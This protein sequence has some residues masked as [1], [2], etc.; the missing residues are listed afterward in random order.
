VRTKRKRNMKMRSTLLLA[1][2]LA[3]VAKPYIHFSR[4]LAAIGSV[5]SLARRPI[6]SASSHGSHKRSAPQASYCLPGD[7]CWPSASAWAAL[8]VSVGGSLISILPEGYPCTE[9]ASEACSWVQGNW[10]DPFW[11][12]AQPGAMQV[13]SSIVRSMIHDSF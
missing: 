1:P 3:A 5:Q 4:D 11:R 6:D 10:T 8:N 2:I 9:P 12:R 13:R 7:T